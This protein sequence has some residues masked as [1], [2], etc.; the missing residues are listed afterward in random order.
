MPTKLEHVVSPT[1]QDLIDL[2]KLYA[3][4][5]LDAD[6]STVNDVVKSDESKA[7]YA[8]RFNDRLLGAVVIIEDAGNAELEYLCVR[9]ITRGRHVGR[10]ILRLI[11]KDK[12]YAKVTFTSCIEDEAITRLFTSAGFT[13]DGQ[14]GN[15]YTLISEA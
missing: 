11:K 14:E 3:D 13:Q 4:Y 5:P 1:E 7:L 8:L 2:E 15:T 12:D 9:E 10:D 6:F